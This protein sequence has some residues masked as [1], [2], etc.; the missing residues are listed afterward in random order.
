MTTIEAKVPDYLARLTTEVAEREKVSVDQIVALALSA[1]VE[2]WRIRGDME[3]RARRA[4]REDFDTLLDKA[5]DVAPMPGDELPDGYERPQGGKG[6][7]AY[8]AD[9]QCPLSDVRAIEVTSGH[10]TL[11][12]RQ[13]Y[14]GER[15]FAA[16]RAFSSPFPSVHGFQSA[17]IPGQTSPFS[18]GL[19]PN[20]SPSAFLCK[21]IPGN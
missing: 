12:S 17:S 5:P 6:A 9:D 11:E 19:S 15:R 10:S 1:Q 4:K 14:G 18:R 7:V 21:A 2:S 3:T 16:T 8:V 13:S 20:S